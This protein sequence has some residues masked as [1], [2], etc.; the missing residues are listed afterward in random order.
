MKVNAL[1]NF[2]TEVFDATRGTREYFGLQSS[3]DYLIGEKFIGRV[4]SIAVEDMPAL[5][6]EIQNIFTEAELEDYMDRLAAMKYRG[7]RLSRDNR[8]ESR[9]CELNRYR[10]ARELLLPIESPKSKS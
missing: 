7:W 10:K 5:V 3:L 2:W 1:S 8:T 6:A 9:T 4:D